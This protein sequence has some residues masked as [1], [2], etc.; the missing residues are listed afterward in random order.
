MIVKNQTESNIT[1]KQLSMKTDKI[2]PLFM[3]K[4]YNYPEFALIREAIANAEDANPSGKKNIVEII[5]GNHFTGESYIFRCRDFGKGIKPDYFYNEFLS[6]GESTKDKSSKLIGG[7]GLGR[8]AGLTVSDSITFT[9]FYKG[10]KYTAIVANSQE[11][12]VFSELPEETTDEPSGFL[13]EVPIS[14]KVKQKIVSYYNA[15][16]LCNVEIV[17]HTFPKIYYKTDNAIL[18]ENVPVRVFVKKIPVI[19]FGYRGHTWQRSKIPIMDNATYTSMSREAISEEI[20]ADDLYEKYI[21]NINRF[22]DIDF[23]IF[24]RITDTYHVF[25]NS[26]NNRDTFACSNDTK[27]LTHI[28]YLAKNRNYYPKYKKLA[29]DFFYRLQ[30]KN[31]KIKE[32]QKPVKG[33]QQIYQLSSNAGVKMVRDFVN[34]TNKIVICKEKPNKSLLENFPN[35]IFIGT[36]NAVEGQSY[37]DFYEENKRI[38]ELSKIPKISFY[39]TSI[40]PWYG[41]AESCLNDL[42]ETIKKIEEFYKDYWNYVYTDKKIL[43][44]MYEIYRKQE[45]P[46]FLAKWEDIQHVISQY[47]EIKKSI[48]R[49]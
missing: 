15:F 26:R 4:L 9:S 40:Y 12:Y 30:E 34:T 49:I 6:I 3:Q 1:G 19:D 33:K 5:S 36:F 11:G 16:L 38:I 42:T 32:R 44:K 24:N 17:G 45:H 37:E 41:K 2:I 48:K 31:K 18:S 43:L 39:K 20:I 27:N 23:D 21:E 46:D 14:S 22:E 25:Q 29:E 13:I 7:Y 35:H 10:K 47:P 8:F 28:P